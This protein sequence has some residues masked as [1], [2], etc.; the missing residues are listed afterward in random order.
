MKITNYRQVIVKDEMG[1]IVINW[2]C[3]FFGSLTVKTEQGKMVIIK[4][5]LLRKQI[6]IPSDYQSVE[7]RQW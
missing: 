3:L 7:M 1:N 5:S 2:W 4:K 6:F